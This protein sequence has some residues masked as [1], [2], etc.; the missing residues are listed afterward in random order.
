MRSLVRLLSK[1]LGIISFGIMAFL[2]VSFPIVCA[3]IAHFSA[4][5]LAYSHPDF[6]SL[7][8]G[9]LSLLLLPLG[10]AGN[11][12]YASLEYARKNEALPSSPAAAVANAPLPVIL[13]FDEKDVMSAWQTSLD[14]QQHFN[15]LELQIRNFAITLLVAVMGGTA[16]TLKEHYNIQ[17]GDQTVSLAVVVLLAGVLG[18][19]A[20][21]FMDRHWYHRLLIGSV[22][23]TISNIEVPYEQFAPLGLS[24]RIGAWSAIMVWKLDPPRNKRTHWIEIHST[25]K[26]DLF[27][28]AGLFLFSLLIAGTLLVPETAVQPTSLPQSQISKPIQAPVFSTGTVVKPT[29]QPKPL[30]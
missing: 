30:K 8:I 21:Y 27:Y 3:L 17:L 10:I 23:H 9:L 6:W 24:R 20:F 5:H 7:R 22:T 2:V 19:L 13:P 14:V 29:E 28:S 1:L 26:I 25:E 16:F 15:D 18:W 11:A 12:L 4:K